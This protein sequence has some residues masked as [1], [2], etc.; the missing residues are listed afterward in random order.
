MKIAIIGAGLGGLTFGAFAAK[1]GHQVQIFDKNHAP[2]GVVALLEHEGY[3]FEQG[4][5]LM[6]DMMPGEG[7]YEL[8][9][10]LGI[11]LE[12]E[13]ADRDIVMPDY[14]M[15]KPQ[16]YGGKYWRREKLKALFPEDAEGIDRYYKLYDHVMHLRWLGR[17]PQTIG[18]KIRTA[19][20]MLKLKPYASMNA[21]E[22][23][24]HFF[25]SEKICTLFTGIFADFCADPKEVQGL[26]VIFMNFETAFDKRIPVE[27]GQHYYGGYV[28]FTGGCQKLPEALA[29]YIESHGGS[30]TYGTV[31]EKVLVE[32]NTVKGV[33]LADGTEIPAELVVGCGA[34]K[35]FFE[36]CVGLENLSQEYRKILSSFRPMEAVFMVHLGVD[37][38]PMEHLRSPL[39]YCYGMYDLSDATRKLRTNV[40]HGGDDGYLV[41]V[42][43]HHAPDFAP[44]GKH[45]V[46]LYTVCPDTLAE[47]DW[48][49]VKERY[50]DRL[51]SLAEKQLPGLAAHTV[52]RK[53]MTAKDY[54]QFTH[55]DKSSFGGVVPIMGQQNPPHQTS[56]KGLY[57]VG[58]QSENAGG[59]GAVMM[60]AKAAWEKAKKA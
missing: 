51:V 23:T 13:R 48:D 15:I 34:G 60:G 25:K 43:S 19:L 49:D 9:K 46:T 21:D 12:T 18:I 36:K 37:Y 11:S 44:E 47:G 26:G 52:T 17:Q 35:D 53:I 28:Y 32:Q 58:Q 50:A 24:R 6:G 16:E 1:E 42:P 3:K 27:E 57:F 10:E 14:D 54:R 41:Y 56:V 29:D 20:A 45:C 55:M 59:V 4:P 33:R 7:L 8:L 38:D 31:V 30:I 22:F 2:G 40:Y 5:L 39:T